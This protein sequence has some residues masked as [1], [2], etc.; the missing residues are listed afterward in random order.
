MMSGFPASGIAPALRALPALAGSLPDTLPLAGIAGS[1]RA[2]YRIPARTPGA[3]T[4]LM[5][6]PPD[7]ADFDRFVTLTRY[8][9]AC[10]IPV[11]RLHGVDAAMRQVLLEDL[12]DVRLYDAVRADPSRVPDLYAHAVEL[13]FDFQTRATASLEDC[14]EPGPRAFDRAHLLWETAYFREHYLEGL[15]GLRPD[16]GLQARFDA[17][18]ARVDAHPKALVHRDFQSQNLMTDG[19]GNLRVIDY[20]GARTG[21]VFYDLASLLLDPYVGLEDDVIELLLRR[22]HVRATERAAP[23]AG[24]SFA[25]FRAAFLDAGLQRVMQALGA[26][27][28]LSRHKGIASF[29]EHIPA[30]ERRLR[31]LFRAADGGHGSAWSALVFPDG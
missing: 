18:A 22:A 31:W 10:G 30:G 19:S 16:A 9:D 14:P 6:S 13:V 26:F 29:A 1:R 15:R 27:C 21:S 11:P 12:G 3:G 5:V 7:D 23:A 4:V 20:Q 2:Y 25:D 24:W 8:F 28:F 17:L